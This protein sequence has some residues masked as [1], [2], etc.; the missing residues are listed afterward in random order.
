[1]PLPRTIGIGRALL[2]SGGV[3]APA[4]FEDDFARSD[5]ALGND[6]AGS[7]WA[8]VGGKAVNTPTLGAE[9]LTDPG[10]EAAYSSGRCTTLTLN[11]SPTLADET[12]DI[13]GGAHAQ[14]FTATAFNNR[15]NFG[16][17]AAVARQWYQYSGWCKRVSGTAGTTAMRAD[18]A[19]GL[20]MSSM[21]IIINDPAYTQKK[22][23]ILATDT[24]NMFRYAMI[25]TNGAGDPVLGDDYSYKAI[26]YSS[27]FALRP[28]S[29]ADATIKIKFDALSEVT[30]FGIIARAD[31]QTSPTHYLMALV[32]RH[33]SLTNA[34]VVY[35]IKKVGTTYTA[36]TNNGVTLVNGAWLEIRL[37]G[38]TVKVYYNNVQVGS[39][40][41]VSDTEIVANAYHGLISSGGEKITDFFLAAS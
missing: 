40:Q 28:A 17:A 8:I 18:I 5:G 37:T 11:G 13:H 35:L 23:A 41:T 21:P 19:N 4:D 24:S 25:E 1:M 30:P 34:A 27:L 31:A 16:A 39:D 10:L 2:N 32:V 22:V 12:V 36:L 6:W 20:P 26:T 7:T 33:Q 9:L 15:L 29:V 14:K 38:T 3:S